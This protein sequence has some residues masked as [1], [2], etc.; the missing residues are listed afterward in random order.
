MDI[1]YKDIDD[2]FYKMLGRP[3]VIYT[4]SDSTLQDTRSKG[5]LYYPESIWQLINSKPVKRMTRIFQ[6]GTRIYS[7]D[8]LNHTRL[9]HSKGCYYRTL[10]LLQKLYSDERIGKLIDDNEYQKYMLAELVRA[11]LHDIGHGPF[12]H[13]MET[14]CNLPKGFHEE[15]RFENDKRRWWIKTSIK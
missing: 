6:L 5:I 9:E 4:E 2:F 8:N 7:I 15:I 3:E 13:T 11:L 12:S 14:V 10:E 1:K